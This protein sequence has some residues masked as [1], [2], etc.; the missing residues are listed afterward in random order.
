RVEPVR[1][2]YAHHGG[3]GAL[4]PCGDLGGSRSRR[5]EGENEDQQGHSPG[6]IHEVLHRALTPVH[7]AQPPFTTAKGSSI[8][9]VRAC[10]AR[11]GNRADLASLTKPVFR[12]PRDERSRLTAP[13]VRC[14]RRASGSPGPRAAS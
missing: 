2:A 9:A 14:G 12:A 13:I 4:I 8:F 11:A 3:G 1:S 5:S 6:R 10:A 7:F